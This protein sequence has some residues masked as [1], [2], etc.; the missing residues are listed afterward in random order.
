[1]Q[2]SIQRIHSL[3]EFKQVV[4]NPAPCVIEFTA[5]D[6]PSCTYMSQQYHRLARMYPELAFYSVDGQR[7][8]EIALEAG[9]VVL[10]TLTFFDNGVFED[11]V[12]GEDARN[13]KQTMS[14]FCP[15]PV[16]SPGASSVATSSDAQ[17]PNSIYG[18]LT[19]HS[20]LAS[21]HHLS[22]KHG[23][24]AS[25]QSFFQFDPWSSPNDHPSERTSYA[26]YDSSHMEHLRVAR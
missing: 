21:N 15:T 17:T 19:S 23:A 24:D 25:Q 5:D 18:G 11:V 4:A 3:Q 13:L 14:L 7:R 26:D 2:T 9:I 8:P 20:N 16:S 6:S 1:M 22:D 12:V 10:P